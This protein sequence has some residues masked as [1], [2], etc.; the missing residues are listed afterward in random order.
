[1]WL[2]ASKGQLSEPGACEESGLSDVPSKAIMETVP[3]GPQD[4]WLSCASCWGGTGCPETAIAGL[5]Y[6]SLDRSFP[7][8]TCVTPSTKSHQ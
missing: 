7:Y 5:F 8:C 6:G 1:M 4:I 2:A 3:G